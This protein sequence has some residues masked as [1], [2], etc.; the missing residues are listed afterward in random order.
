V[1][2][3]ALRAA[4]KHAHPVMRYWGANGCVILGKDAA[5]AK[6][7]LE[8][9]LDDKFAATR[10]VAAKALAQIGELDRGLKS[11]LGI[12]ERSNDDIVLL[13]AL[14]A[15]EDLGAVDQIPEPTLK[16]IKASYAGRMTKHYLKLRKG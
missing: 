6:S 3:L 5:P 11:L 14:N 2:D 15:L 4:M 16:R 1:L 12:V 13:E 8:P 7:G 10:V 9:L